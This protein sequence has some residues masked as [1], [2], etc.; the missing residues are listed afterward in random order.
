MELKWTHL[1]SERANEIAT[2]RRQDS[3][4][5]DCTLVHPA[6]RVNK[7]L[8]RNRL[9]GFNSII[10]RPGSYGILVVGQERE[11]SYKQEMR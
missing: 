2:E 4:S 5:A 11:F 7:A 3:P 9:T 1:P 10:W 8:Y 6:E